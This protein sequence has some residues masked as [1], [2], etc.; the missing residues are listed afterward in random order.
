MKETIAHYPDKKMLASAYDFQ[1]K[2]P[3]PV[4]RMARRL[5]RILRPGRRKFFSKYNVARRLSEM[6]D[7]G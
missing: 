5:D 3:N 4:M 6:L 2:N 7:A 1:F